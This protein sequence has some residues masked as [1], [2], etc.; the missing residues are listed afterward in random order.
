MV[1]DTGNTYIKTVHVV[2]DEYEPYV[3]GIADTIEARNNII[4]KELL[5]VNEDITPEEM[6]E[7]I[8]SPD[9]TYSIIWGEYPLEV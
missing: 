4:K 3:Y 5:N 7:F 1:L 2:N 6:A 9:N 8:E